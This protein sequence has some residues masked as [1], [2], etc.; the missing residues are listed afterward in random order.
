MCAL[1][2]VKVNQHVSLNLLYFKGYLMETVQI[3]EQL[4]HYDND[5]KTKV[6][7]SFFIDK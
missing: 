6:L 4:Y 5:E 1:V 7:Q 2:H 3:K